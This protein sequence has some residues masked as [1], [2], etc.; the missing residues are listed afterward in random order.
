MVFAPSPDG[1]ER[2]EEREEDERTGGE[3]MEFRW[4]AVLVLWTILVGPIFN[5]AVSPKTPR[6]Q[7]ASA[8]PAAA[9]N[10]QR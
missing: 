2:R 3:Q 1:E 10:A 5:A 6:A 4:I 9:S 7:Q 8:R